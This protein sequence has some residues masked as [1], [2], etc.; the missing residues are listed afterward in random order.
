M[1]GSEEND[2]LDPSPCEEEVVVKEG[3]KRRA[4]VQEEDVDGNRSR[5]KTLFRHIGSAAGELEFPAYAILQ[6]VGDSKYEELF[7]SKRLL[8]TATQGICVLALQI[9]K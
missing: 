9:V 1:A 3:R 6:E 5:A 2:K 8:A 7:S 4:E